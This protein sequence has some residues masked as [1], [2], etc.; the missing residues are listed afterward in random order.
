MK[1]LLAGLVIVLFVS[2]CNST[3][4]EMTRPSEKPRTLDVTTIAEKPIVDQEEEINGVTAN[5]LEDKSYRVFLGAAYVGLRDQLKDGE[6]LTLKD[7]ELV[8]A[9]YGR[10]YFKSH[11]L[12]SKGS[13]LFTEYYSLKDVGLLDS[14]FMEIDVSI[15]KNKVTQNRGEVL[16]G[17]VSSKVN[18]ITS[19][20]V[21]V[22]N[23]DTARAYPVNIF[24]SKGQAKP[25]DYGMSFSC[26]G[27][28]VFGVLSLS[29]PFIALN[30]GSDVKFSFP[31]L[32]MTT[33]RG[34]AI[35]YKSVLF[36]IS[37]QLELY[38]IHKQAGELW[39]YPDANS[40]VRFG[41]LNNGMSEAY[42]RVKYHCH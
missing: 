19:L 10:S 39:V 42:S 15:S 33:V 3:P 14:R 13:Q 32:A 1:N 38:L 28:Q 35:D 27:G 2:G 24:K 23:G 20:Y 34:K 12:D 18:E 22:S 40:P 6:M 36:P 16:H 4:A 37:G 17:K 7:V 9:G 41:W 26:S 30:E 5:S 25:S 11:F 29:E 31:D 21:S 8:N